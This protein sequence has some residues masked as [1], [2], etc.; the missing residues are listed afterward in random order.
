METRPS[1]STSYIIWFF[2]FFH[3]RDLIEFHC[4]HSLQL[5]KNKWGTL[6]WKTHIVANVFSQAEKK[7]Y[8][9]LFSIAQID[10]IFRTDICKTVDLTYKRAAE[11]GITEAPPNSKIRNCACRWIWYG[12]LM[13]SPLGAQK[14]ITVKVKWC[15]GG[16]FFLFFVFFVQPR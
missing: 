14:Q 13:G 9:K 11:N 1:W 5:T 8:K 15:Y 6:W 12:G 7:K 4:T 2:F 16:A 10:L 3:Q